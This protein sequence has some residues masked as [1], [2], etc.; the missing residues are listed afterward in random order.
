[1]S[2][3]IETTEND[4][5]IITMGGSKYA[6]DSI[7][8]IINVLV[9]AANRQLEFVHLWHRAVREGF[10]WEL[11]SKDGRRPAIVRLEQK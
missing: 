3:L 11:A 9:A 2:V 5:F 4:R 7:P 8:E 10:R 6:V 1:M